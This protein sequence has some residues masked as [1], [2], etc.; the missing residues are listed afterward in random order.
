MASYSAGEEPSGRGTQE[1]EE[2]ALGLLA[3]EDVD[4]PVFG[5]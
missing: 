4:L 1:A 5:G 2:G 3:D